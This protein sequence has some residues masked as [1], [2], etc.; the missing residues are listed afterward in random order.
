MD[1]STLTL[2][3]EHIKETIPTFLSSFGV[4]FILSELE[5]GEVYTAI[6]VDRDDLEGKLH[7]GLEVL[8]EA[9]VEELHDCPRG[10]ISIAGFYAGFYASVA[11]VYTLA[12]EQVEELAKD[13]DLTPI[14]ISI[15]KYINALIYS[16]FILTL[17]DF[18]SELGLRS[19][20]YDSIIYKR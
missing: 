14:D 8:Y 13:E 19:T 2:S 12:Y 6:T 20:L 15:A 5:K 10:C 9:L 18:M 7:E 3:E 11:K 17:P 1:I 16:A 4:Q